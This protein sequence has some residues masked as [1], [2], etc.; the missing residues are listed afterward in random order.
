MSRHSGFSAFDYLGVG[1]PKHV[2]RPS[3]VEDRTKFG[4]EFLRAMNE[5]DLLW[6]SAIQALLEQHPDI[7]FVFHLDRSSGTNYYDGPCF[8][9]RAQNKDGEIY[10]LVDGGRVNWA[11][12]LS[13]S[14]KARMFSTGIG[15]E[16]LEKQF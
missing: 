9:V 6:K 4:K 3:E 10:P 1:L 13:G 8:K 11:N 12:K 7:D 15:L 5:T 16:L 2:R 14:K